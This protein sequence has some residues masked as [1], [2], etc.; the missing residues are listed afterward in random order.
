MKPIPN[1][2]SNKKYNIKINDNQVVHNNNNIN[3]NTR[4]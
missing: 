1:T 3:N 4:N 2:R